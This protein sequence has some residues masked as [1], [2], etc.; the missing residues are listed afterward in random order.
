MMQL[1]LSILAQIM[2]F[3]ACVMGDSTI[4]WDIQ[5]PQ[6]EG[7]VHQNVVGTHDAQQG[8]QQ[9][10]NCP[11]W[12]LEDFSLLHAQQLYLQF[13]QSNFDQLGDCL[14]RQVEVREGTVCYTVIETKQIDL[15]TVLEAFVV[16]YQEVEAGTRPCNILEYHDSIQYLS[17]ITQNLQ[18]IEQA[19]MEL[20][21]AVN[22]LAQVD[23]RWFA[24]RYAHAKHLAAFQE[25][26]NDQAES[27]GIIQ[28][29]L[30]Q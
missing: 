1:L 4:N 7:N 29:S 17:V 8:G 5:E 27:L 15:Q 30:E 19:V 18:A 13:M 26:L 28:T 12:A 20:K 3:V 6:E 11:Y 10:L 2:I 14:H 9:A 24:L 16:A 25:Y 22:N 21:D 23:L